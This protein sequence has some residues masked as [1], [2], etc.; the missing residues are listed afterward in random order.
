MFVHRFIVGATLASKRT[1]VSRSRSLNSML[2]YD[3]R[4]DSRATE[5]PDRYKTEEN[6]IAARD[7]SEY[8]IS[9]KILFS[10]KR[11]AFRNVSRY[12]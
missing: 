3:C 5:D 8:A 1:H 2:F 10:F 12:L 6:G 4:I 7:T 9:V 11:L